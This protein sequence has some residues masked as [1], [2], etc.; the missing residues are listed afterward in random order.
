MNRLLLY[1]KDKK[2]R[3]SLFNLLALR[4]DCWQHIFFILHCNQQIEHG[5]FLCLNL[6]ILYLIWILICFHNLLQVGTI[7]L[8]ALTGLIVF[9]L[10]FLAATLNATIIALLMSLA[11]AGGFLALFFAFVT[12]I[13]IGALSVAIFTISTVTFWT[14]VAILITTGTY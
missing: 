4:R 11:A 7:T 6:N 1:P 8:V 2:K 12:A 5:N 10:F 9:M 13:Y 3:M 14:V